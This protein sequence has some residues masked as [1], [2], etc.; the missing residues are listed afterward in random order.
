MSLKWNSISL[1]LMF[2]TTL[3]LVFSLL[4]VSSTVYYLLSKSLR[5]ND[6]Q[7]LKGKAI[8][9][10][11]AY[12]LGGIKEFEHNFHSQHFEDD[13]NQIFVTVLNKDKTVLKTYLP[14]F[15][16]KDYEDEEEIAQIQKD[17]L[18]A[19]L[20]EGWQT[21]LLL[22]GNEN[23]NILKSMEYKLRTL[24]QKNKWESLLPLIDNDNFE[25]YTLRIGDGLWIKL[26]KS[27]EERDEQLARVRNISFLVMIPFMLLGISLSYLLSRKILKP[28]SN[29][30]E[31]IQRIESGDKFA[32]VNLSSRADEIDLLGSKFNQLMDSNDKLI[33]SMK[34]TLDNV[35]HDIRTPLTRFKT[36][37]EIALS[38]EASVA[39]LKESLSDAIEGSDRISGILSAIMDTSESES[40]LMK[41]HLE[42]IDLAELIASIVD[43]YQFSAE[44]KSIEINFEI[45]NETNIDGDRIRLTQ[46][47]GNII[48]NAIKYSPEKTNIKISSSK[49]SDQV[50]IMIKDQGLGMSEEDLPRIWER[51]YRV[52]QGRSTQGLGIG[53]SVV[54]S[55]I[56]AHK[57]E[58]HCLSQLGQGSEFTI[59]LPVSKS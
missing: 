52:D 29:M 12:K 6:Q 28:V 35:A 49:S 14:K 3:L 56:M 58:V 13:D 30:V 45:E 48:D 43:I 4:S 23:K 16:E 18:N 59:S 22:S 50:S 32:R 42:K 33:N 51:L 39:E 20:K 17:A 8:D 5:E 31:T 27:S 9:L 24:V 19:E 15:L 26:G 10:K 37:A 21:I 36:G 2:W 54:K 55:I 11:Y 57:G 25:V 1:R 44:E 34:D 40:G 7:M 46:A 41:L 38:K 47:I 53:L